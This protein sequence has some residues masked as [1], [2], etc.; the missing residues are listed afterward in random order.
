MSVHGFDHVGITV[1]DLDAATEFF[2][3][4]GLEVEGRAL[5][6]GEFIETVCGIP[7]ARSEIVMLRPPG[8]GTGIEL[9]RFLSPGT[10]PGNPT[11]MSTELGIRNVC[12]QVDDVRGA[13]DRAAALGYGLVGG[14][15]EYEGAWTMAYLRGPDGIV[16]AVAAQIGQPG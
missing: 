4:L 14:V 1:S 6:E 11:A 2:V 15:G 13:V 7:G 9:G 3:A 12:L 16:V 8:G 5:I 10:T